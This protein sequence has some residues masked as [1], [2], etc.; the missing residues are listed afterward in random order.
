MVIINNHYFYILRINNYEHV[1]I[2]KSYEIDSG[3]INER[4]NYNIVNSF[5]FSN[6]E[7]Q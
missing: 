6:I 2:L 5:C 1:D 4:P 3:S 7:K